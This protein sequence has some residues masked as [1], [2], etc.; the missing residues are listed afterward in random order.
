VFVDAETSVADAL[1]RAWQGQAQAVVVLDA[2]DE[3]AAIVDEVMVGSVP[4]QQRPWTSIS[5]VAR[6]LEPG[7]VL[8]DDAD[9][10]ELLDRI[11]STPARE[12]L[13]MRPDGSAAGVISARDFAL[14]LHQLV[15]M[16]VVPGVRGAR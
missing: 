6:P 1:H 4:P 3:P 5:T 12:Y 2:R 7:L 10:A 9:A 14:Q 16:P 8:R 11:Q 13:V 15:G